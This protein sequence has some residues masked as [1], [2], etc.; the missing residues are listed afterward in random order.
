MTKEDQKKMKQMK[1]LLE[2]KTIDDLRV[3]K[4]EELD[5]IVCGFKSQLNED[6]LA[7]QKIKQLSELSKFESRREN[8]EL[9]LQGLV[10]QLINHAKRQLDIINNYCIEN[11]L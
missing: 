3:W 2:S 8:L 7:I 11:T 6:R 9:Y 4:K 1:K 10:N 5:I